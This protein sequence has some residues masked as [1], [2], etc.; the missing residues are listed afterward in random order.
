M[1][2]NL[3]ET[4]AH[5][6]LL[7]PHHD[8]FVEAGQRLSYADVDRGCDRLA[9]HLHRAGLAPGDRVAL[10]GRN[11]AALATAI[12]AASRADGIAVI[13]NWRLSAEELAFILA[14]S[15]AR[16]LIYDEAFAPVVDQLRSIP[17]LDLFVRIGAGGEDADGGDATYADII[18]G[19][20][21]APCPPPQR[22][23]GDTAIILYTSGT[24]SRPKGAM[25]TH[26]NFLA[27]GHGMA[28]TIDWLED[29]RFL[30]VAPLFHV[31]GLSPLVTGIQVGT[32]FHFLADFDPVTVWQVIGRERITTMM[33]VPAMLSALLAVAAR[34]P[35][36]ASSLVNISCGASAVPEALI[37]AWADQGV[38]VQQ[39]YGLTEMTGAVSFWK[40]PMGLEKC[41]SQGKPAFFNRLR[42][43]DIDSGQPVAG[44]GLRGEVLCQGP[45]VFAG[46]WNNPAA[47]AAAMR[48]DWFATGDVGYLDAD[49]FLHLVDRLKDMI[50]SGGENIYP[51]EVERVITA[52]DGV[53]EAAVVG[54]PDERWGEAAVAFVVRKP[55]VVLDEADLIAFCQSHLARFKCPKQVTFLDAL[56]RNGTGKIVKP[57]LREILA[58][59][60]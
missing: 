17:G 16:A 58:T 44:P 38:K 25:L 27:A 36:D 51:A 47:S 54:R 59:Q 11:S 5:R 3:S 2:Y 24:T 37:R 48:G 31:G 12:F 20:A 9:A 49:G 15:G 10:Y 22:R 60:R 55:G 7:S 29:H 33:T 14:D 35:V 57:R 21:P 28:C 50:I 40:S 43:V 45:T 56:P 18:S 32:S 52:H 8:G 30:L 46:Y 19:A 6:A 26:D 53:A 39:V 42:I 1:R 41:G 4:L 34:M 23:G 13:L